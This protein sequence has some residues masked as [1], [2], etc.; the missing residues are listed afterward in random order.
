MH[1]ND[2]ELQAA[3]TRELDRLLADLEAR[4]AGCAEGPMRGRGAGRQREGSPA[5]KLRRPGDACSM[6]ASLAAAAAA[7]RSTGRAASAA[8][9]AAYSGSS[10]VSVTGSSS[11]GQGAPGPAAGTGRLGVGARTQPGS[12]QGRASHVLLERRGAA[13]GCSD[14]GWAQPP[15]ERRRP[16][17]SPLIA[18]AGR[19]YAGRNDQDRERHRARA[20][21][22]RD[23][24]SQ[25]GPSCSRAGGVRCAG[26]PRSRAGLC[27]RG[28]GGHAGVDQHAAASLA[29]LAKRDLVASRSDKV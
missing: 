12:C 3:V 16:D 28:P 18:T 14:R 21:R 2:E 19:A 15:P 4:L 5:G 26:R 10:S 7:Q 22:Q 8:R 11:A 23:A 9:T 20:N 1:H 29:V 24:A 25:P 13:V 17:G 6:A 27:G